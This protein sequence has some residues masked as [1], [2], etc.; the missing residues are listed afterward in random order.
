[1]AGV[2]DEDEYKDALGAADPPPSS[3]SPTSKPKPAAA[4]GGGGGGLGRRLFASIPLPA[5]LSAAI[6]RFSSPKPPAPNVGLGLLLHAGPATP[7]DG[8]GTPASDAA[9]AISSPHLPPLVSLQPQHGEDRVAG[10]GAGMGEEDLGLV[11]AEEQ[12]WPTAEDREK[13]GLAVDECSANR[14]DFSLLGQE[15]GEQCQGDEL[16]AAVDGCMVQDQEEV[17][18]QEGATEDC[19][20]V[21]E[22]QSN[23]A[24]VEQC[25]GD[26]TRAVKD[27]NAVEVN[28]KVTEQEGAVSILDAAEDGVAVGSQE[29]EEDVV[30]AEQ[31][32][33]VI[34][35][36]DQLEVVEL[37]TGDQLRTT[38]EDNAGRDQDLVKQEEATEYYTT[39]E[40][41]EQCTNDGSKEVKDG[42]IVE[43]EERAVELEGA[44]G[45]LDAA[46][47]GTPV[48]LQ[49]EDVV[50]A[51]QEEDED[52]ISVQDQ[53]KV[54]DQ[55]SGDQLITA[56]DD[57]AAQDQDVMK[58]EGATEYYIAVEA[59]EQCTN[60]GSRA[61]KDGNVVEEK[62]KV[63]EQVVA[64]GILYAA[65]DCATGESQEEG[66]VVVAEQSED[67][68][69]VQDQHKVVELFTGNQLKA[70]ADDNA[71]QDQEVLEQEGATEY[72][73]TLEAIEECTNDES[74]VAKDGNVV[75]EKERPVKQEGAVGVLNAA[76]DGFIVELQEEDV[77]VA[78][79]CE[80]DI[81]VRNQDKVVELCTSGQI[82][83]TVVDNAAEGQEVVEEECAIVD[84]DAATD[85]IAVED[86]EKEVKQSAGDESRATKD[87]NAVEVNEKMVD[88]EDVIDKH[89]V[90]KDGNGV[91]LLEENIV[92]VVE[93]GGDAISLPD[94]S[95]VEQY[96]IDQLRATTDDNAAENQEIGEQGAVVE[97]VV[98]T[99]G[100]DIEDQEKEVEH[101]SGDEL[102]STKN[103]NGVEDNEKVDQEDIIDK[104][105]VIKDGSG[106][107]SQEEDVVVTEQGGD[108]ISVRDVGNV[109]KQY[110]SDQ[111]TTMEDNVVECQEVVEKEGAV[112]E[113]GATAGGTTV[114]DQDKEVEQSA[115]DESRATNDENGV[116]D[117]TSKQGA[118]KDGSGVESQEDEDVV[119]AEQGGVDISVRDEGNVMEQCTSDQQRTTTDDNAAE[120][121]EVVEQEGVVSIL[122]A[123]KVDIA[124]E[125]LQEEDIVVADQVEDGVSVQD[126][127]KVVEQC[128]SDQLRTRTYGYAEEDQEARRENIGFS[129]GY[130]QRP[131][132]LN[133]RFYMLNGSC[134]YGSSCHFNHPQLKAKL[135]VSNFPSEQRNREVEFLELNR[136]GLPIREGARKCTYYMR[137][138]TCRYGKKCCFN[139]PEQVL[140]AQLHMPTGWDDTN[141]QSS[142]HSKKSTEHATINDI[143]SGLE[144]LPPN[145]SEI[146]PPNILRML[147]PPQNVP[148]CT[149]EKEMKVKKDP[150][151]S[152][153]S[154]DSDGCCSADSSGGPLCKQEHVDYPERP[155]CPFLQRFGNCKFESA[156]QY[157]HPKDKFPC[158]HHPKDKFPSRYHSKDKFQSRYLPKRDPPLA[159]L[160]VYPD[161]PGEP[162]CPFYIKTGSCKFRADCKFHHPKDLTPSMQGSASPK[163]SV[164]ANEHH[165]A[166]RIPSMQG[167]ASPKRLV[168]NEHHPAARIT[169][170]DHMYQQQ[171]CPERPGE[172]DCRYYMQFGKCK[173]QSACI[174]NH[175]KDIL[176]SG[177]RPA[178]CPFYMKT[179]TCQFGS[180]CEFSHPKDRCATTGEAIDDGTDNEH[181]FDTKSENVLQ[182]Q[183]KTIYPQR[184]GEPECS[185]YMKHGYCKFQKSCIFHHP[186]DHLSNK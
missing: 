65:K 45:L 58:H 124:V 84:R 143:S 109:V 118:A 25:A 28:E 137:N 69:S 181:D 13:E 153:A 97:G 179:G 8:S 170:Q 149:E 127:D 41:V 157:Y 3:P 15:E 35:V 148:P 172:P 75:E 16:G 130:P 63:A 163:R 40:A 140:D 49:E 4:A 128:T 184:P 10:L 150:D 62:D 83:T 142:P 2:E 119:P 91:V 152:S 108:G 26:E 158:R 18:E 24:A 80:G 121:Q 159:E 85:D 107:D 129:A 89:G 27:D 116:E 46:K 68:I 88:Q 81:F 5:S 19:A 57:N 22:D 33:D 180:A 105:G 186:T 78:E 21:V 96:T 39:L 136:V 173:F 134:S 164:A 6:G 43:E 120:D 67:S 145:G 113:R 51:E 77:M 82:K 66:D 151:W 102:T 38:T 55:C 70:S 99:D 72:Y 156:C 73:T 115:G 131:G 138:G 34:S 71:A 133:C 64:V 61:V 168:A 50:V 160:K 9:S 42:N 20:A 182:Q 101:S 176:S 12:V 74:R 86:Q 23:N 122:G 17:V 56:T 60:D 123:A 32:E 161:R 76:K 1:M 162:E 144:I 114:E 132:K 174:F 100:I 29:E 110:T 106:V 155:E 37:C 135:E 44:P 141:L 48:E 104:Q 185:H 103:E 30:V 111:R 31:G 53:H 98:T 147:L 52:V 169:L 112:F 79:Q 11:P 117:A 171:K 178:A 87:G 14:N 36:Q 125:S 183:E 92:V 7:A 177:W 94:V 167:P 146:L 175:P 59:V 95:N 154:D 165:P 166:A 126:Q 93:Q 139:H 90:I 54:V 47:D